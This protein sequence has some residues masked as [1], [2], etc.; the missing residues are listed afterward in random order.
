MGTVLEERT[1]SIFC[2]GEE[3]SMFHQTLVFMYQAKWCHIP[4]KGKVVPLLNKL[5][6]T[7]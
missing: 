6:F 2:S 1:T 5:N 4:D 3:G 7:P